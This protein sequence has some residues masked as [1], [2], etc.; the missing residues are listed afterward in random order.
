MTVSGP[1]RR[2]RH[3]VARIL[4]VARI[5]TLHLTRDRTTISLI[6]VV[7]AIQLV[8][9]GYAVN[10]DPKDVP[11]LRT[12]MAVYFVPDLATRPRR[13]LI[14]NNTRHFPDGEIW[15]GFEFIT[16]HRFQQDLVRFGR[17]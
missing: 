7:P 11:I 13:L 1:W 10:L 8:L 6:L 14:T 3:R 17:R 15:Q 12:A 4:A 2:I 16:A 9:F 5:E